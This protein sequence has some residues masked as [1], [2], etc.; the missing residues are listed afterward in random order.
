M[1]G[2]DAYTK[3]C[4]HCDGADASTSFPDSSADTVSITAGGTAQVD[5]AQKVF[6]TGS[7]L[8]D[9][10]SDYLFAPHSASWAFGAGNFTIDF[11]IR[12]A[13]APSLT[14]LLSN[15]GQNNNNSWTI[16]TFSNRLYFGYT[17]DG[18][19]DV[20]NYS[21]WTPSTNTWYHVAIV[22][23][24]ADLKLY[25]NGSKI[26]TTKNVGTA[27]IYDNSLGVWIGNDGYLTGSY[28]VNGWYDEVR[29]SKGIARWTDDTFTVPDAEYSSDTV[30]GGFMT[31][32]K[33][34]WGA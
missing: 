13:G 24:G 10:N 20:N 26:G 22:R 17:T 21:S 3:L 8:L 14:M 27:N 18:V 34:F 30:A 28:Y 4:L 1:A 29:I 16:F 2:I 6:G 19:T 25:I 23:N 33:G 7:C 12:F 32:N 31:T 5:T 11:R 15:Y 9:G